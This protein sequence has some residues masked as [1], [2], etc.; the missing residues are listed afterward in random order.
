M[1][2]LAAE[3]LGTTGM[4]SAAAF[5]ALSN[6]KSKMTLLDWH[7]V[8]GHLNPSAIKHLEKRGLIEITDSTTIADF[9][10]NTCKECKSEALS[11]P[12][13]GRTPKLQ[14]G[15]KVHTDIAG[16]FKE[17]VYGNKWFQIFVDEATRD[18]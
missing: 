15:E 1:T 16:P 14:P 12:R 11:F 8:L 10:C 7:N 4:S 13:G 18:K 2:L 6:R 9:K 3:S 5:A 17:D